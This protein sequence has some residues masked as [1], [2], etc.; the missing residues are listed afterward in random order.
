MVDIQGVGDL[1][2]DPQIH[3]SEGTEYGD[4]NLGTKGMALFFHSHLCNPICDLLKLSKFDLSET[5]LAEIK[6]GSS[7]CMSP[8]TTV[9]NPNRRN[10]CSS[11]ISS[12][13]PASE[14]AE[15]QFSFDNTSIFNVPSSP[16]K[17]S[18]R[19]GSMSQS[20]TDA[21]NRFGC[22]RLGH[23]DSLSIDVG[24]PN[25]E[26]FEALLK[27]HRPSTVNGIEDIAKLMES[28]ESESVLGKIHFELAKYH[29]LGRFINEGEIDAESAL[30]H[31][32]MTFDRL[33]PY[34]DGKVEWL[35]ESLFLSKKNRFSRGL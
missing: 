27:C 12:L 21:D 6:N 32:G 10:R 14:H 22:R 7:K 2:T 11:S 24:S 20:P 16:I 25:D 18:S 26:H 23:Q 28:L 13:S 33:F 35:S 34:Q 19:P 17:R 1:Y 3:T 31:L 4:G 5:E 8:A 29:E 30:F 9:I 15:K